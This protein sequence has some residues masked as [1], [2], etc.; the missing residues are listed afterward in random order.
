MFDVPSHSRTLNPHTGSYAIGHLMRYDPNT[1]DV[2]VLQ[3]CLVYAN[4][5]AISADLTHLIVAFTG[6]CKA[7]KALDQRVQGG[8]VRAACRSP[9]LDMWQ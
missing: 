1:G 5:I 2:A 4:G 6:P 7:A 3:T 8:D 9:W